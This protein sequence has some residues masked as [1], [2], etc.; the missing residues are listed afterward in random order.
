MFE[1]CSHFQQEMLDPLQI[2]G[3][4]CKLPTDLPLQVGILKFVMF[5]LKISLTPIS[6][7][8]PKRKLSTNYIS[9][10]FLNYCGLISSKSTGTTGIKKC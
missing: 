2:L 7:K 9:G 8:T 3:C 1:S 5:V 6:L 4:A 10:A